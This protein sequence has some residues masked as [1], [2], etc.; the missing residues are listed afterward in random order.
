MALFEAQIRKYI[1]ENFS[2]REKKIL[3]QEQNL[4]TRLN[5]SREYRIMLRD[6]QQELKN[7]EK[8]I[9]EKEAEL[10]ER[11]QNL[12]SQIKENLIKPLSDEKGKLE[13]QIKKAKLEL[14]GYQNME[15]EII[16][17]VSRME[18]KE[19]AIFQELIGDAQKYDNN[20]IS[21]DG[22]DFETFVAKLLTAN[23]FTNVEVTAKSGD[24][25]AD[26]LANKDG[27]KYVFQCKYYFNQVGIEAVQQVY[28][29]KD[30]YNAHVAIVITNSVFTKAAK[31][32][33][34]ELNVVLWDC[35]KLNELKKV[36]E[37]SGG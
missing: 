22:Y 34:N 29:A 27:I 11:E 36:E 13:Q 24:Y 17:W 1:E 15:Y 8:K 19:S 25:G 14:S 18:K 30:F 23:Q 2:A 21:I 3:A 9:I 32:L 20:Q 16:D 6:Y 28:S 4:K 10:N 26:V 12:V 5:K 33:A 37:K 31:V 7:R 35:E